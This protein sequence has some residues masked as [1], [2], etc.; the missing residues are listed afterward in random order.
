MATFTR[1]KK[2]KGLYILKR[3]ASIALKNYF[4]YNS[5]KYIYCILQYVCLIQIFRAMI[6]RVINISDIF[7]RRDCNGS[8]DSRV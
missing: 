7:R 4:K 2:W 5:C 1:K 8:G 6:G 3:I